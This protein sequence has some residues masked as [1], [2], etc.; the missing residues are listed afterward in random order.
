MAAAVRGTAEAVLASATT[1]VLGLLT[2]LLS[3]VPTTRGLGLACAVGVVVAAGFALVVLPCALVLF[4]RWVFWP[5]VPRVGQPALVDS[6][7]SLWR[8]LG[9]RVAARPAWF[10]TGAVLV[11]AVLATGLTQVQQGLSESEQFLDTPESITAAERLGE[12]FPA[13]SVDPTVVL[14]REDPQRGAA[15]GRA[16]P[17]VASATEGPRSRRPRPDRR[18]ARRRGRHR[19]RRRRRRATCAPRSTTYDDTWVG[20]TEAEALDE[21]RRGRPRPRAAD[22]ADPRAGAARAG[23]AAALGGR[24][25]A[26][27]GHRGRHL[28]RRPRRVVVALHRRLRVRGDGRRRAAAGVPVPRGARRRLQHLP[29]HPGAAGVARAR[30]RARGCCAASPPPAG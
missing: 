5:L 22:P 17:G 6:R 3:V 4:G 8:R 2:L 26:A 28:L 1:V 13:G 16:A 12:S 11:V 29:G 24:A 15:R 19:R 14:T 25:A 21:R 10:A 27:R 18:R 7:T 30:R 20:G 23:A 9:D